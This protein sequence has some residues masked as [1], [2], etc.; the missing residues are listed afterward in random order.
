MSHDVGLEM[1]SFGHNNKVL[2]LFLFLRKMAVLY[3]HWLK[4]FMF[5]TH[6]YDVHM[7]RL[8]NVAYFCK[9]RFFILLFL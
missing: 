7:F 8:I 9:Y 6:F 5:Q 1:S 3:N 4:Y 2:A